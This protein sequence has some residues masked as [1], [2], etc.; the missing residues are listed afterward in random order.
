MRQRPDGTVRYVR[1]L[2]AL[3]VLLTL[4][5]ASVLAQ[6]APAD[7]PPA[8][9]TPDIAATVQVAVAGTVSAWL[10]ALPTPAPTATATPPAIMPIV[11]AGKGQMNTTPF[12]LDRGNYTVDWTATAQ[13]ST[14]TCY[15]RSQLRAVDGTPIF[16][17]AG[18]GT[19]EKGKSL[20]GTTQLYIINPNSYYLDM[21]TGC[22]WSVTITT[23]R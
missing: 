23:Q 15:H 19:V 12:R 1:F 10:T 5:S 13:S 16:Q 17:T 9:A 18:S 8:E 3:A 14:I 11:L 4:G 7:E 2:I 22:D 20:A 6:E 21:E